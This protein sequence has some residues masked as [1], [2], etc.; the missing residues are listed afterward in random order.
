VQAFTGQ[1][2]FVR[3]RGQFSKQH[4]FESPQGTHLDITHGKAAKELAQGIERAIEEVLTKIPVY[5]LVKSTDAVHIPARVVLKDEDMD[6]EPIQFVGQ[7]LTGKELPD[8]IRVDSDDGRLLVLSAPKSI[9]DDL[10]LPVKIDL[11][12]AEG[13][14]ASVTVKVVGNRYVGNASPW[15]VITAPIVARFADTAKCLL[16]RGVRTA[17]HDHFSELFDFNRRT[18]REKTLGAWLQ[19]MNRILCLL[20]SAAG[21]NLAIAASS[22]PRI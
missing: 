5:A 9:E 13:P 17:L 7:T 15:F 8:W 11:A 12:H 20:R 6:Y 4:F 10:P 19:V 18:V 14:V 2:D 21:A 16:E 1:V 3:R 22:A